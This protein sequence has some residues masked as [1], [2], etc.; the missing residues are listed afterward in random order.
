LYVPKGSQLRLYSPEARHVLEKLL[1]LKLQSMPEAMTYFDKINTNTC[2]HLVST[3]LYCGQCWELF[4]RAWQV[5][6]HEYRSLRSGKNVG[7]A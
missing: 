7:V 6:E 1:I 3:T 4:S 5:H 2:Q